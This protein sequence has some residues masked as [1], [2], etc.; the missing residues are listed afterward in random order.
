M[1]VTDLF[2]TRLLLVTGKG[3]V[4]KSTCAA[5]LAVAAAR[6]GKRTCLV[7][8]EGRQT[9]SRLF[10]TS[11]WDFE[12]REFREGLFGISIDAEASLANYLETFYGTGRLSKLVVGTTAAQF[13]T[14]SAP[15]VKDVLLIGKVNEI[16]RRR[17]R[18]GQPVYDLIV[19]DAPPT[20]RI[21]NFLRAPEATTE[22]VSMGPI[23][24]QAQMVVDMLLDP[25]RT[26]VQLVTLLE[27]LP[28]QET[29]EGFAALREL[30]VA[31]GPV[32]L[33]RVLPERFDEPARKALTDDLETADLRAVLA[34]AGLEVD[35]ATATALHA[36]GQDE[37][38]R[39]DRQQALR[40]ELTAAL[41]E[42]VI[43]LPHLFGEHFGLA[44]IAR[45]ADILAGAE[46]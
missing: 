20:G 39:T 7:E 45:L 25:G 16:E 4:G 15:G 32:L 40:E 12:E 10:E 29:I 18:S 11:A 34:G 1:D 35:D 22:L 41:E 23:R 26:H 13:V 28:V 31:V 37:L 30:G 44:E 14:Q 38:H 5:A 46:V 9:M 2:A 36:L 21:V 33:N 6:A 17:D 24:Q 42:P 3:G 8:V 27:E 19:V 43:E